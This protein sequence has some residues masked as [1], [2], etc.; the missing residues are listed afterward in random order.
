ME[1]LDL[2]ILAK[3][4][5]ITE[6]YRDIETELIYALVDMI[7]EGYT[8]TAELKLQKLMNLSNIH[9]LDE[10]VLK[11]IAKITGRP[12]YELRKTL[13]DIAHNSVNFDDLNKAYDLGLIV[14]KPSVISLERTIERSIE[15]MATE[16]GMIQT[17]IKE[18]AFT[19]FRRTVDKMVLETQLG[20]M[21]NDQAITKAVRELARQGI[22]ASTYDR[23]GK[24]V[25]VPLET[26]LN[27]IIR[28][29]FIQLAND[30]NEQVVDELEIE[31]IYTSQH[32][33]ARNK[34]TGYENH[35]SW[36]GRVY[37]Y[38]ELRT[39]LGYG[40]ITGLGGINCRHIFRSF[41]KGVSVLPP[42]ID[43][44]KNAEVYELEQKQRAYERLIRQSKRTINALER[45]PFADEE[46]L[47]HEKKLLRSR[48]A[49]I[50]EFIASH[51]DVLT[52]D[53]SRERVIA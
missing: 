40:E 20:T 6:L 49:R 37:K 36:Q 9:G 15:R 17:N 47:R 23:Q 38:S 53:Y 48:Q 11:I 46:Q 50:R 14:T 8:P 24:E 43:D 45:M 2:F 28:S 52:R 51:K 21:T 7:Q 26:S 25:R 42:R 12:L 3:T 18:Y 35:E 41:V 44:Q 16:I 4:D 5:Y 39:T 10:K 33:G 13:P 1:Q 22:T 32:L 34:G 31:H 19:D 27:R 29:E 30:S